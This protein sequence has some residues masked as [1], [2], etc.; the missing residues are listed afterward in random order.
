MVIDFATAFA[1][2]AKSVLG[3]ATGSISSILT[4]SA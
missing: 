3:A 2:F 4:Q 1:A